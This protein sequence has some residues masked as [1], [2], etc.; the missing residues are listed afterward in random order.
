MT[1]LQKL[2]DGL[3]QPTEQRASIFN[4]RAIPNYERHRVAKDSSGAPALLI[5]TKDTISTYPIA[6]EHLQVQHGV[7]CEVLQEN[8]PP[9]QLTFSVINCVNG[10]R[11]LYTYFLRVVES[12]LSILGPDPSAS[13]VAQSINVLI[14]LFRAL[15]EPSCKSLQ[16][17]WAELFVFIQAANPIAL[18]RAWHAMPTDRHDFNAGRHRIEVKSTLGRNRKHRFSLEQLQAIPDVRILIASIQ[19]ESS[20][21][22]ASIEDLDIAIR[23]RLQEDSNAL[24]LYEQKLAASLG[25]SWRSASTTRFDVYMARQSLAFFDGATVPTITA[26]IPREVTNVSFVSDLSSIQPLSRTVLRRSGGLWTAILQN[27]P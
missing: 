6:L 5:S 16:G 18:A 26:N 15:S 27:L 14:S 2:F 3:A 12:V 25:S 23:Q 24:L 20:T 13:D 10:D 19:L 1:T 17:L 22:G 11:I 8:A 9:E 21:S 4:A 7:M